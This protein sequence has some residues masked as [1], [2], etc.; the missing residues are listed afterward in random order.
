MS[1]RTKPINLRQLMYIGGLLTIALYIVFLIIGWGLF[2]NP[3]SPLDHWLSDIGRYEVPAD[4]GPVWRLIAGEWYLYTELFIPSIPNPGAI[5]YNL[6]CILGGIGMFLF[7]SGFWQFREKNDRIFQV[8]N[9]LI[10]IL[11]FIGG[12][13]LILIGIFSED[14]IFLILIDAVISYPVHHTVTLIF[15]LMLLIIKVLAGFWA[16]KMN[17][18]RLISLYSWVIIVFDAIVVFTGNSSSLI[19]WISVLTSLGLLGILDIGLY[20]SELE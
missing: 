16:W 10:M 3:L 12:V 19:E 14:G 4:G 2:P 11:G 15:F 5:W 18:N 9:Y 13:F 20:F 7:F 1:E 17:F 8:V 6:A